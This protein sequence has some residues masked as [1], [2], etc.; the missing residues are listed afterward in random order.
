M[1]AEHFIEEARRYVGTPWVHQ[2]RAPGA[3]LDC[4]G[5][6]VCAARAA[7][8][9]IVDRDGYGRQ[10]NPRQLMAAFE[11]NFEQID[12][13]DR[14]PGDLLV[15]YWRES[16]KLGRLPQHAGIVTER[17]GGEGLLHAYDRVGRTVETG[18]DERWTSRVHSAWRIPEWRQS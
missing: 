14:R 11:E 15:F 9:T 6:I 13:A 3:G 12:P 1:T 7:G 18:L 5:I 16:R 4:I 2:G 17:R 10:P 8:A